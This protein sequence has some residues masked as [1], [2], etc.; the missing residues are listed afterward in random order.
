MAGSTCY[1][2]TPSCA[3][4]TQN[5]PERKQL[6]IKYY[7]DY[8]DAGVAVLESFSWPRDALTALKPLYSR[9]VVDVRL[10]NGLRY[11]IAHNPTIDAA[12]ILHACVGTGP[13]D[14]ATAGPIIRQR[15]IFKFT[16]YQLS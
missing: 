11:I 4:I 13:V 2:Q 12:R 16:L 1:S 15:R 9:V 14:P 8:H 5:C 3:K 7:F 6:K 10:A